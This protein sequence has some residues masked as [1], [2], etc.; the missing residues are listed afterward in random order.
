[1]QAEHDMQVLQKLHDKKKEVNRLN[2]LEQKK[3]E[4]Q[5]RRQYR[6]EVAAK[7]PMAALKYEKERKKRKEQKALRQQKMAG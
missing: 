2:A 4:K 5:L 6:A 3:K 7:D 1:M